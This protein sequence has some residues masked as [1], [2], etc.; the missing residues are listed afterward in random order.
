MSIL[1]LD[2]QPETA[3][4]PR[5]M[6]RQSQAAICKALSYPGVLPTDCWWTAIPGG[7]RA[8]TLTPGY[9]PGTTDLVFMWR[10]KT[11]WIELKREGGGRVSKEQKDCHELI[12]RAGGH[13][14]IARTLAEVVAIL[15]EDLRMPVRLRVQ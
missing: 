3:A 7:D 8:A 11:A 14:Y 6:E 13:A 2:R 12:E 1:S 9:R 10:G 4:P 5:P 15:K